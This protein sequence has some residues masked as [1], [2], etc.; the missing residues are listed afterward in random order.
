M[1]LLSLS[2]SPEDL[3]EKG[4]QLYIEFRPEGSGWGEKTEM[5]C[6]TILNL[7]KLEAPEDGDAKPVKKEENTDDDQIVSG[8]VHVPEGD[9]DTVVKDEEGLER[10]SDKRI[11]VEGALDEADPFDAA[12]DDDLDLSALDEK[13]F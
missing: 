6:K 8:V 11:K 12:L 2:Y 3:N 10:R 7:R 5:L 4:Y 13:G 9:A 1:R